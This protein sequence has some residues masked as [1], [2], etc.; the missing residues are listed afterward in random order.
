MTKHPAGS[1]PNPPTINNFRYTSQ[2]FMKSRKQAIILF[3]S[4]ILLIFPALSHAGKIDELGSKAEQGQAE[5]QFNLGDAYYSGKGTGKSLEQAFFWYEKAALQ[6]H[7]KAQRALGAMYELGKGPAPKEPEKAAY[8]Y[9]KAAEQGLARAQT[10]L[11][12]LYETG[13]GVAQN[14]DNARIWYEKAAAQ[15]DARGQTYLGRMYEL[16][17]GVAVDFAKAINWYRKAADQGYARAQTNLGALYEAGQGV[18]QDYEQAIAWYRAAAGQRY[19][20]AHFYLGRMFEK[21]LGVAKDLG[22]ASDWYSEAAALGHVQARDQLA[23][24][25]SEDGRP[26]EEAKEEKQEIAGQAQQEVEVIPAPDEKEMDEA[27]QF[28][29][30]VPGKYMT[31][32]EMGDPDS[33]NN[34]ALLYLNGEEGYERDVEK[35]A[36][37]FRRAAENGNIDAQNNLGLL[38]L[39]S[40]GAE[41]NLQEA[42]FWL[43][44]AA[45]AGN[46]EAQS[47][48]GQ[49]YYFEE[50]HLEAAFWLLQAAKQGLANA[51]NNLAVMYSDGLGVEQNRERAIYWLQQAADQGDP[52]ARKNLAML[53]TDQPEPSTGSVLQGDPQGSVSSVS[54]TGQDTGD[55]AGT[56]VPGAEPDLVALQEAKEHFNKGNLYAEGGQFLSA[57]SEYKKAIEFDPNNSNTYENLAIALAQTGNFQDAVNIM[58]TAIHLSPDDAMKYSTLAI[59][60]HGDNKLQQAL[61][62]YTRSVRLNPGNGQMYY[63]MAMIYSELGQFESAYRSCLQAQSLGYAGSFQALMELQKIKPELSEIS[64][65]KNMVLHLRHIVTSTAAEAE[66][67]LRKLHEGED[68]IQLAAQFSSQTFNLNG[69]YLGPFDPNE[70]QPGI[71]EVV[72]PLP[73]LAF[74]PVIDTSTGFHIFQKFL[75]DA[76]LFVSR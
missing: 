46:A 60:Y 20:R 55:T 72:A 63:N 45:E 22:R 18:A 6:G 25:Q 9:G 19:A 51:Q 53:I 52:T 31:A 47:N 26:D 2:N 39:D 54:A 76:N 30:P 13:E 64:D 28:T 11:G 67:V 56:A 62:Q 32:A 21:G 4:L 44:K 23:R 57:I 49:M 65:N 29:A 17:I 15:G 10:N 69:G 75:V 71:A 58:Q 43:Q 38:Y 61:E 73:L 8:W 3:C 41:K 66:I 12:I 33:Q 27:Q 35:A 48:L 36:Y 34:L 37:W 42:E 74:S 70:L 68:F 7:A 14:Y 1:G 16:G 50:N 24:L 40:Q 5:A 59:I